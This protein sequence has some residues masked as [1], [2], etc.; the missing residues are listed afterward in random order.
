M[1]KRGGP[2]TSLPLGHLQ[3][4]VG[5]PFTPPPP[6]HT[7]CSVGR[8]GR[9]V[10]CSRVARSVTLRQVQ[11][12]VHAHAAAAPLPSLR[13]VVLQRPLQAPSGHRV[14]AAA[15]HQCPQ[16]H[17]LS[18][19]STWDGRVAKPCERWWLS[20]CVPS[21]VC[22][23]AEFEGDPTPS[24]P[25][26]SA[27]RTSTTDCMTA[28]LASFSSRVMCETVGGNGPLSRAVVPLLF[29]R[30]ADRSS[31]PPTPRKTNPRHR[32]RTSPCPRYKPRRSTTNPRTRHAPSSP[33]RSPP[34]RSQCPARRACS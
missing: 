14:R 4:R 30:P 25:A 13:A 34:R 8:R 20:W 19:Y 1:W 15:A 21:A 24:A 5:L 28:T 11:A 6:P 2:G 29:V 10:R 18:W 23:T 16:I 33:R 7:H 17:P 27:K 26:T 22:R 3:S 12:K 31:L 32:R 9:G